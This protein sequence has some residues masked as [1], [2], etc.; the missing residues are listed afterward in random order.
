MSDLPKSIIERLNHCIV[1]AT[2]HAY[3]FL[4]CSH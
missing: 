2:N 1:T 3:P 4:T